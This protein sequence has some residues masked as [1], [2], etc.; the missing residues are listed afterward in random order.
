MKSCR[1]MR[2]AAWGILKGKWFGR[3][4]VVGVLLHLIV[5]TVNSLVSSAFVALSI[6][7]LG[8]FVGR[9]AQAMQAGL[10]YTLPSMRAYLWMVSGFLFQV[11]IAY[12]FAAIMAYGFCSTLLKAQSNDDRR[13]FA[14]AFGGFARP[15][16]VTGLLVLINLK[17]ALWSLLF[18]I[19]GIVAAYRYRL[20]WFLKS[21]HPDWTARAC[22]AES[23]RRMSGFKWKAFCLDLSYL[24][25][26]LLLTVG[27]AASALLFG[28]AGGNGGVSP[29]ILFAIG[30]PVGAFTFYLFLKVVLGQVVSRVVFYRELTPTE[31]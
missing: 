31:D 21:E 13:W 26:Y 6:D 22:V 10:V 2:R 19:P 9:K 27:F 18:V 20:A 1:E 15:F 28:H 17:V 3:L 29:G 16:E 7:S 24:G 14:D 12:V 25:W 5:V 11:F 4:L 30:L 8:E 23:V